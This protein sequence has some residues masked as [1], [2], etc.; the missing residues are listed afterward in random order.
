[1]YIR[2]YA[3]R[4]RILTKPK[5]RFLWPQNLL[6]VVLSH[7]RASSGE[8]NIKTP[9]EQAQ[10]HWRNWQ[11]AMWSVWAASVVVIGLAAKSLTYG[12]PSLKGI[13]I[14]HIVLVGFL[15]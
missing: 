7:M 9:H 6:S 4:V 10:H 1:M 12:A 3:S 14:W 5:V 8:K 2:R 15:L 11:F 13:L